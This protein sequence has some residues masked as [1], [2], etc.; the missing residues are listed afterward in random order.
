MYQLK[1]T[2]KISHNTISFYLDTTAG[3]H[4]IVKLGGWDKEAI[5]NHDT[6]NIAIVQTMKKDTWKLNLNVRSVGS[7]TEYMNGATD[8]VLVLDPQI[9][10]IYVPSSHFRTVTNQL[11]IIYGPNNINT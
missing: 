1:A 4:T 7:D 11:Q 2:G 6:N 8:Q 5:L 10:F 9:P 3:N